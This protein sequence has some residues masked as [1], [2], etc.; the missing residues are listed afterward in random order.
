MPLRNTRLTPST[1]ASAATGHFD[2]PSPFEFGNQTLVPHT[3]WGLLPQAIALA[4]L[5]R[6]GPYNTPHSVRGF[7][8][9]DQQGQAGDYLASMLQRDRP[10][11]AAGSGAWNIRFLPGCSSVFSRAS[12]AS[13]SNLAAPAD[14]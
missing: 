5:T 3:P 9:S 13:G 4:G 12:R 10:A 7:L 2:F 11:D 14:R 8:R 6:D 1:L